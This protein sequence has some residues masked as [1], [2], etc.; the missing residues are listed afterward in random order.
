MVKA[1]DDRR[2]N[3]SRTRQ[4]LLAARAA[5]PWVNPGSLD[6]LQCKPTVT[7][8]RRESLP[9]ILGVSRPFIPCRTAIATAASEGKEKK[10]DEPVEWW[11]TSTQQLREGGTRRTHSQS[12]CSIKARPFAFFLP[13]H[14]AP[15]ASLPC[16]VF[17][18]PQPPSM[19][20][21]HTHTRS[22]TTPRILPSSFVHTT[23]TSA[24]G[25][26]VI[27]VT[28][29]RS[30]REKCGNHEGEVRKGRRKRGCEVLQPALQHYLPPHPSLFLC[31]CLSF[32]F[33]LRRACC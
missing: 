25:E 28:E 11:V 17:A 9:S 5:Q 26:L 31:L 1:Q 20:E 15:I 21:E 16:S 30:P 23:N 18:P 12:K 14:I 4:S 6:V 8:A 33:S 13:P 29:R 27:L 3:H 24:T 2:G 22:M 19:H 10:K 7:L 32:T